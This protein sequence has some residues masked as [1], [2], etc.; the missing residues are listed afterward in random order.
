MADV[1][2]REPF[3]VSVEAGFTQEGI[4]LIDARLSWRDGPPPPGCRFLDLARVSLLD[5]IARETERG[6][7]LGA[8]KVRVHMADHDPVTI[9][10]GEP[11]RDV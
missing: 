7:S 2:S 10:F 8:T 11:G 5:Y 1:Y 3:T 4:W 6:R 9:P